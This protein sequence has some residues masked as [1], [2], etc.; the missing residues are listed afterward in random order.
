M[1]KRGAKPDVISFCQSIMA[2]VVNRYRDNAGGGALLGAAH[3][4]RGCVLPIALEERQK[5]LIYYSQS[6]TYYY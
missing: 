6:L 3:R 2:A 4:A 5:G 1:R